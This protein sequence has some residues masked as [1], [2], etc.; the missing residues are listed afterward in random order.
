MNIGLRH[1][2]NNYYHH[3]IRLPR[4]YRAH[5]KN[6]VCLDD[7]TDRIK[8][9]DILAVIIL[10]NES[11]RIPYFLR[12]YRNL[13]V[14][15]FIFIDNGSTDGLVDM[16]SGEPDC[17]IFYTEDS[18]KA[19]KFGIYWANHILRRY[20]SGHWCLML[21]PDEFLVY[22]YIETRSLRELTEFLEQNSKESFF[23]IM[24]DM[25]SDGY[26]ED[27]VY[28]PGQNPLE[29][30]NWFDK[31][32]YYQEEIKKNYGEWWIRGGVRRRVFCRDN[33]SEAPAINK[34]VLVK[35][36]P[37]FS[38]ISSTHMLW[39]RRLN[40]PHFKNGLAPTGCLLHFKFL[41]SFKDK[42]VEEM[43][44][45]QHYGLS[46]EYIRYKNELDNGLRLW[47]QG[48]VKYE[49]WQQCVKLGLMNLGRWF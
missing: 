44:R 24:L 28:K 13:G 10:R 42:V 2:F 15:H 26:I 34:T 47:H 49:G 39:P 46:K 48:S 37:H 23:S 16:L 20:G 38:F 19:S 22:P 43:Q 9:K 14:G 29:V 25:Y 5:S 4:L 6:M 32:G 7:K 36:Q 12:Y 1:K 41:S 31:T 18:Y 3:R 33:P 11:F 30:C 17:S 45:K 35:W 27:A 21:D 40:R 8:D